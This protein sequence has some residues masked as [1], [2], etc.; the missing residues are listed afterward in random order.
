MKKLLITSIS[1]LFLTACG[2]PT[3]VLDVEFS[4]DEEDLR[5]NLEAAAERV[6][7]RMAYAIEETTPDISTKDRGD[8][9]RMIIGLENESTVDALAEGLTT[10][11]NLA[12]AIEAQEGEA[13]DISNEQFGNFMFSDFKGE[14]ITWV[15][16]ENVTARELAENALPETG[17]A[18]VMIISEEGQK[19]WKLI[20]EE[21]EGKKMGLFVRGGLVS[22]TQIQ[23]VETP[24]IFTISNIP[25]P[26][27][28]MVFADDINVGRYATFKVLP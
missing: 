14:H 22:I 5:T 15:N 28:G 16:V 24:G 2:Q 26:E 27:L 1:L 25:S 3:L 4:T 11:L 10:P 9:L 20:Q 19:I 18:I 21:H 13:P 23:N 6:I 17:I 12:F 8:G 7:E